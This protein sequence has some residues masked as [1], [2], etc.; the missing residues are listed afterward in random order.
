M[1]GDVSLTPFSLID[2]SISPG[3]LSISMF[4]SFFEL[5][6]VS[7]GWLIILIIVLDLS[8]SMHLVLFPRSRIHVIYTDLPSVS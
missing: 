1:V 8:C 4:D 5:A 6:Y 7:I 3:V 2:G